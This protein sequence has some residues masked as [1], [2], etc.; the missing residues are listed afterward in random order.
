MSNQTQQFLRTMPKGWGLVKECEGQVLLSNGGLAHGFG[1][2]SRDGYGF[3]ARFLLDFMAQADENPQDEPGCQFTEDKARS[4]F[5]LAGFEV[6]GI[7]ELRNQYWPDHPRYD[8]VRSPWW[9]VKTSIGLVR[10]GW[11]KRV[12]S[13]DWSDSA[14]KIILTDDNVT[15]WE[16]G[17]H[18]YG[19][20]KAVEYLTHLR[21]RSGARKEPTTDA[22]TKEN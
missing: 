13:I 22:G 7:W 17:V 19:Y 16:E 8:S 14:I 18:A 1:A 9:L 21:D 12:L 3:I 11:R 6:L 10:I 4:L 15:K 20:A 5:S 2:E